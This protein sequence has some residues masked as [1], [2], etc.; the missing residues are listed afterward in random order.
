MFRLQ[1]GKIHRL[2]ETAK[3][4]QV[5]SF[6]RYR[7]IPKLSINKIYWNQVLNADLKTDFIKFQQPCKL[8]GSFV[9]KS[10]RRASHFLTSCSFFR[11]CGVWLL[12]SVARWDEY[13]DKKWKGPPEVST[14]NMICYKVAATRSFGQKTVKAHPI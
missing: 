13:D 1:P 8:V 5:G 4:G 7:L 11:S 2:T 10:S 6:Y 3:K 12:L 9:K 14:L